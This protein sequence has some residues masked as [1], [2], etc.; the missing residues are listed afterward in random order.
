MLRTRPCLQRA[1]IIG[2]RFLLSVGSSWLQSAPAI[3]GPSHPVVVIARALE[4]PARLASSVMAVDKKILP[5]MS[6]RLLADRH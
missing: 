5:A 2:L 1:M 4:E 6:V 3:A